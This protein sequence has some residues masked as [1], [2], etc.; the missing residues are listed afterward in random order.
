ML[1]EPRNVVVQVRGSRFAVVHDKDLPG[2]PEADQWVVLAETPGH[3]AWKCYKCPKLKT[4]CKHAKAARGCFE[5]E[6]APRPRG[7]ASLDDFLDEAG[8]RRLRCISR[9]PVPMDPEDSD[10]YNGATRL[11]CPYTILHVTLAYPLD[12]FVWAITWCVWELTCQCSTLQAHSD[13]GLQW[14]TAP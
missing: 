8:E 12:N 6:N 9:L 14:H 5:T 2:Q 3:D 4:K 11:A 13:A 10:V 1:A 7:L